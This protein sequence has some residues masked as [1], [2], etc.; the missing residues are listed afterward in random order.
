MLIIN[1]LAD[2]VDYD[3][4]VLEDDPHDLLKRTIFMADTI[5]ETI[6]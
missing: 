5:M 6:R 1:A 2:Y 4:D 3:S